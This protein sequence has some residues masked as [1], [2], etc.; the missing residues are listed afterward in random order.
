MPATQ[1]GPFLCPD[2]RTSLDKEGQATISLEESSFTLKRSPRH[3]LEG[4]P[5]NIKGIKRYSVKKSCRGYPDTPFGIMLSN[6]S[7]EPPHHY[8]GGSS[9]L[10]KAKSLKHKSS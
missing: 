1:K 6:Y 2:K 3:P 8:L 9:L 7:L 10:L 5:P 4:S